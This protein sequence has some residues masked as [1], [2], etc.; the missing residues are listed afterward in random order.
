MSQLSPNE[1]EKGMF[2]R[3]SSSP[4]GQTLK[5]YISKLIDSVVD[6]RSINDEVDLKAAKRAA[7]ILENEVVNRLRLPQEVRGGSDS[8]DSLE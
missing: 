2:S 4:D 3:L 1:I 7:Q 5:G 8:R 6:A